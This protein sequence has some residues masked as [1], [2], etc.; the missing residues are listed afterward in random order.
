MR[1][2]AAGTLRDGRHRETASESEHTDDSVLV[3]PRVLFAAAEYVQVKTT[4][5]MPQG[6]PLLHQ[7]DQSTGSALDCSCMPPAS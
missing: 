6:S 1:A 5:T 4:Q 2:I 3:Q 7:M